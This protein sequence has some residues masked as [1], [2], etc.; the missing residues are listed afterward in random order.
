MNVELDRT[1]LRS[2]LSYAPKM[3]FAERCSC[4]AFYHAGVKKNVLALVFGVNRRTVSHIVND[5]GL[6]YKN[7]RER[8]RELGPDEFNR[9]YITEELTMRI[10][11]M[12]SHPDVEKTQGEI[13]SERS[14]NK[15]NERAAKKAGYHLVVG[16]VTGMKC[17]VE[18]KWISSKHDPEQGWFWFNND[19]PD[20]NIRQWIGPFR[21]SNDALENA[22]QSI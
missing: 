18:V 9:T 1:V 3:S 22:K 15:P 8:R 7:V 2:N 4:L 17:N 16:E 19:E 6:H 10:N 11:E 21:T 14:S 20:A 12:R 13:D 5:H